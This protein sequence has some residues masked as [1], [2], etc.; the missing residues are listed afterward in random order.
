MQRRARCAI[1][2][3]PARAQNRLLAQ[4]TRLPA[5]KIET[6]VCDALGKLPSEP[7]GLIARASP[8]LSH[9]HDP[10]VAAKAADLFMLVH[11]Q[12]LPAVRRLI[13]LVYVRQVVQRRAA[14]RLNA[15]GASPMS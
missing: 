3:T 4:P 14:R 6:L 1:V 2:T 10:D 13:K 8:E 12:N 5:R 7:L 15:A 9:A 11:T